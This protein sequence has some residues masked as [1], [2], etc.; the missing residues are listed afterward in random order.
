MTFPP[1]NKA[2]MRNQMAMTMQK[3]A[4]M[5]KLEVRKVMTWVEMI[6]TAPTLVM[7]PPQQ[8]MTSVLMRIRKHSMFTGSADLI[9]SAM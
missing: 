1:D 7:V 9:F 8:M 3:E 4:V 6:L 5:K 2:L